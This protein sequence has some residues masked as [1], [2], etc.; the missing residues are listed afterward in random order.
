M[1]FAWS[2]AM[3]APDVEH[4]R[5]SVVTLV[6]EDL[7]GR[8]TGNGTGFFVR[9]DGVVVTNNH[10]AEASP[11]AALLADGR[12][13]AVRGVL[14]TDADADLA[15]LV[16]EGDGY[17]ALPL[18]DG[19]TIHVDEPVVVIGSPSGFEQTVTRGVITAMRDDGAEEASDG[20]VARGPILQIS[21][22]ISPGS[23]GSPVMTEDGHVVGVAQSVNMLMDSYFAVDVRSVRALITR[24]PADAALTPV[25]GPG[26]NLLLTL[27]FVGAVVGVFA[28]PTLWGLVRRRRR[29]RSAPVKFGPR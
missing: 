2:V 15:L 17:P 28:A 25:V 21:A 4:L 23:S 14:A 22:E 20:V 18:A 26:R 8:R 11:T 19:A 1:L 13:V 9:A 6:T 16:L 10:V 24:T 5:P 7:L 29:G 12:R 27:A 3:A